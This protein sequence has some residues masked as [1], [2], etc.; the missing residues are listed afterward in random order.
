MRTG[1]SLY[2]WRKTSTFSSGIPHPVLGFSF[3][4]QQ[5]VIARRM[6]ARGTSGWR[7]VFAQAF[8]KARFAE[9][10]GGFLGASAASN[11][12]QI[13]GKCRRGAHIRLPT[14]L[15]PLSDEGP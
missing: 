10:F 15:I 3:G 14:A 13:A 6:R 8:Q 9:I 4:G 2:D 1:L 7:R 5:T 12:R 11:R